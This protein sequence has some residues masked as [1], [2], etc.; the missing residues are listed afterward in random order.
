[1]GTTYFDQALKS[2]KAKGIQSPSIEGV[3]LKWTVKGFTMNRSRQKFANV[4]KWRAVSTSGGNADGADEGGKA[5][6]YDADDGEGS[7]EGAEDGAGEGH[8]GKEGSE[9]K[10]ASKSGEHDA[11]TVKYTDADVQKIVD[12]ALAK[13]KRRAEKAQSEAEK[14]AGMNESEKEAFKLQQMQDEINDLKRE[15]MANELKTEARKMLDE[16]GYS[17][18]DALLNQIVGSDADDTKESVEA[19]A[20]LLKSEI[21]KAVTEALK[22]KP[23]KDSDSSGKPAMT[24]AQKAAQKVNARYQSKEGK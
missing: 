18:P 16:K 19:F 14:L 4:G 22:R 12:R 15:K 1:M 10:P 7:D 21:N 2:L 8:E 20:N 3:K 23:P 11:T 5:K 17:V 6:E 13:E 9:G 24:D